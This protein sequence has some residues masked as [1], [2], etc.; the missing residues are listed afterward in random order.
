MIVT[1][2]S[3]IFLVAFTGGLVLAVFSM[4]HG[5]ERARRK[6]NRSR[7]P[8]PYFNLP[9]LAAF[10]AGF[11]A[12]GYLLASRT[13]LP[14]W[15]VILI[16]IGG[17]ALAM[18]GIVSL[19]AGWALRGVTGPTPPDHDEIQG[20]PAVVTREISLGAAGQI[21]YESNGAMVRITARSLDT[22]TLPAGAEVVI[23][24]IED[25]VAFVEEWAVVEQRL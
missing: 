10:A 7:A 16:A 3:V 17:G 2:F 8:S 1:A 15:A 4:L 21:S 6:R 25:G 5:V 12:T 24:R 11:G 19:L 18:T 13:I 23:D 20:Q 22:R 9:A 14:I